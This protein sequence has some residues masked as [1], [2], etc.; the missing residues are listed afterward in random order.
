MTEDFEIDGRTWARRANT[1][2]TRIGDDPLVIIYGHVNYP[3]RWVFNYMPLN[4]Y[5]GWTNAA[6]KEEA[7]KEAIKHCLEVIENLKKG[8]EIEKTKATT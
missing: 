3:T 5:H 7:A 1:Y 4:I 2:E 6:T 8:F